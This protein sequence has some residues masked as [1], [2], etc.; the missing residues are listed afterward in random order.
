MW[1]VL[2]DCGF[3]SL[4]KS[5]SKSIIIG[6]TNAF[7]YFEWK[8]TNYASANTSNIPSYDQ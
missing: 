6:W 4:E 5:I 3:G 7:G 2:L 8:R 1:Y